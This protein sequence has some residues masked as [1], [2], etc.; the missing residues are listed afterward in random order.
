MNRRNF[1]RNSLVISG[2]VLVGG[3]KREDYSDRDKEIARVQEFANGGY[4]HYLYREG[5]IYDIN[6]G[7]IQAQVNVSKQKFEGG[8]LLKYTIG[9]TS[10]RVYPGG[11][12]KIWSGKSRVRNQEIVAEYQRKTYKI[13]G[14]LVQ[15]TDKLR[16]ESLEKIIDTAG[17]HKAKEN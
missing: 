14:A 9:E 10:V 5:Y 17:R 6:I 11:R 13:I 7:G 4:K 12:I 3:C 16:E 1:L 15:E 8:N 2:L